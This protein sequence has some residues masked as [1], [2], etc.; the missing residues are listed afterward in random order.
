LS[1]GTGVGEGFV[2]RVSVWVKGGGSIFQSLSFGDR[3]NIEVQCEG[4][5]S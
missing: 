3:S 4:V 5:R 2:K 1:C